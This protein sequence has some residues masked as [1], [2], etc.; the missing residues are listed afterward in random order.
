MKIKYDI[1]KRVILV[2]LEEYFVDLEV[3]QIS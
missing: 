2:K 3:N 1:Q